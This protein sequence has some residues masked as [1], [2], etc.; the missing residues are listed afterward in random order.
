M[1]CKK[2]GKRVYFDI[3]EHIRTECNTMP[4]K[5]KKT[6]EKKTKQLELWKTK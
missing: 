5:E 3:I 4:K 2:C 1:K 6:K